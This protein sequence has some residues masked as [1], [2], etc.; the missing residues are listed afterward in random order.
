MTSETFRFCIVRGPKRISTV[1]CVELTADG[2]QVGTR[3]PLG[4]CRV[5]F[6]PDRLP[7]IHIHL[8]HTPHRAGHSEHS[9]LV[10][11]ALTS[12]PSSG[13]SRAISILFPSDDLSTFG[14]PPIGRS[15]RDI[16]PIEAAPLGQSRA[17]EISALISRQPPDTAASSLEGF[18]TRLNAWPLTM[19]RYLYLYSA[20]VPAQDFPAR[21]PAGLPGIDIIDPI[22]A[23]ALTLIQTSPSMRAKA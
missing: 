9:L 22:T 7:R 13:V 19:D 5:A 4:T 23:G 1:W 14:K 15:D 6:L 3:T 21:Q 2:F 12:L 11:Q 20:S 10:D 17:T 16:H 18:G 8:P